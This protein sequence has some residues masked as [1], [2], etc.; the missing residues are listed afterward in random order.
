M[1]GMAVTVAG[2]TSLAGAEVPL[3]VL[4]GGR[5]WC[6]AIHLDTGAL[7]TARWSL[8]GEPLPPLTL[9]RSTLSPDPDVAD[10]V[11]PEDVALAAPPEAL[12]RTTRRRAERWLRPVLHPAREHLLGSPSPAVPYW[13]LT[14]S[15]PSVAVVDPPGGVRLSRGQCRF[16][17]RNVEHAL[18]VLPLALDTAPHRPRRIVVSLSPPR[19]GHCYKLV[20]ALL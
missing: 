1:S 4:G 17:W 19:A 8:P 14:G 18:P 11:R 9:A 5:R 10:P 7:V 6:A 16:R 2:R 15:S 13:T 3:L 20:A 12:G